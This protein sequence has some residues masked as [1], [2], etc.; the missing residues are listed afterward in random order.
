MMGQKMGVV[1][2]MVMVLM[3]CFAD[4]TRETHQDSVEGMFICM[5]VCLKL[6]KEFIN[7]GQCIRLCFDLC[8]DSPFKAAAFGPASSA[9]FHGGRI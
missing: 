9:A 4:A 2:S 6:C 5:S 1:V 8:K 7:G 3:I